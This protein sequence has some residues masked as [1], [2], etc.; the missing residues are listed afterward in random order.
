MDVADEHRPIRAVL[1]LDAVGVDVDRRIAVVPLERRHRLLLRLGE[2]RRA[3]RQSHCKKDANG[4]HGHHLTAP[5]TIF[6]RAPPSST[7]VRSPR[8]AWRCPA[9]N[10]PSRIWP[11]TGPALA[12]WRC[13]KST[14]TSRVA[15]RYPSGPA[16][17]TGPLIATFCVSRL[18]WPWLA[19]IISGPFSSPSRAN[20]PQMSTSGTSELRCRARRAVI[21]NRWPLSSVPT[22]FACSTRIRS[23]AFSTFFLSRMKLTSPCLSSGASAR[24]AINAPTALGSAIFDQRTILS[25]ALPGT[26][27]RCLTARSRAAASDTIELIR[28][29]Q[30]CPARSNPRYPGA[31][32]PGGS[33][34][35]PE[36]APFGP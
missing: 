35:R 5:C 9:W 24:M 1:H 26:A 20:I 29:G 8:L 23:G 28:H 3:G 19:A 13:F 7:T 16:T 22:Y 21:S 31:R 4:A 11:A 10:W 33:R 34:S 32:V 18:Y 2:C 27:Q 6:K 36:P 17:F 25:W 15:R 12:S 14:E 30:R